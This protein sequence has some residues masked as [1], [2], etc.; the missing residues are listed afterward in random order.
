MP[1]ETD[2]VTIKDIQQARQNLQGL[3]RVTPLDYSRTFSSLVGKEV[4]LK[5]ENLQRTGSFK[6]RGAINKI[7]N[8]TPQQKSRGVIAASA[9]NHAQGVALGASLRGI[10][11]TIFMP[12]GAPISKIQATKNYGAE[13]V[14][15]GQSYDDAYQRA[16]EIQERTKA[17]LIHAFDDPDIV[18]GQGTIGL[19]L[20]DELPDL[21]T[22][23]VPIGGGGLI[24]G[25]A[26]ALKECKPRIKVIGVQA[27]GC[28]SVYLSRQKGRVCQASFSGT[29]A[30]GIAVKTPGSF[31]FP[32][33]QSYVDDI[34]TVEDEE[35]ANAV[36]M[37]LERAKLVVEGSGAVTLA[38]LLNN[39]IDREANNV[40]SI[41]SG[42]NIDTNMISTIIYR[43]LVKAGRYVRFSISLPDKPGQLNK[44][45][46]LI[47]DSQANIFA[48][49]HERMD[50]HAPVGETEVYFTVETRGHEHIKEI[51]QSI[52]DQGYRARMLDLKEG[53]S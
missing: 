36:L 34:V 28:P 9:G 45:I 43:G 6:I 20:L 35:I 51:M 25:I 11:S 10:R 38:A 24:S 46:S 37:L 16:K 50:V 33:I 53:E 5:C 26:V 32:L 17:T 8:L 13:V 14:L 12:S 2:R 52:N 30:D 31:T 23:V 3:I 48:V 40:V 15:A 22:V 41:I 42:G 49:H 4:Y 47:A 19:E 27:A 21:D 29:I 44:I 18:A 39:K 1:V 7:T